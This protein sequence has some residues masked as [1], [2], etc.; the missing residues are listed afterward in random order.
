M[1]GPELLSSR[2]EFAAAPTAVRCARD[3]IT[4]Q[5]GRTQ[6]ADLVDTAVLLVSEL[7]TNAVRASAAA[8]ATGRLDLRR[9]E[10][11]VARTRDTLLI[12]VSDSARGSVPVL[13]GHPDDD[14][15]SGRG[16]QV[17]T[18]LAARWG[19]R[20]AAAGKAV[21]CELPTED[22]PPP[23]PGTGPAAG[24]PAACGPV[25]VTAI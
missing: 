21:W 20:P 22:P 11:A 3:W 2:V 4:G 25:Q 1:S 17:V 12:E 5:L 13:S 23:D 14:A 6:S 18:A 9:I 19:C 8:A 15:E 10:L 7:V 16:L 24:L